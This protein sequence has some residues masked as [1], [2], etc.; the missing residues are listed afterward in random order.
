MEIEAKRG[1]A[2]GSPGVV[3]ETLGPAS[4]CSTSTS[5]RTSRG[6]AKRGHEEEVG[7]SSLRPPVP[8]WRK[9]QVYRGDVL[10]RN[11][12]PHG[13]VNFHR[14]HRIFDLAVQRRGEA[15]CTWFEREVGGRRQG[16]SC[17]GA[18]V[19]APGGVRARAGALQL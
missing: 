15:E 12:G 7:S 14:L 8:E 5:C 10:S 18:G 19:G 17:N 11:T 13:W 9:E 6:D 16:R 3:G 4:M 1:G 2:A